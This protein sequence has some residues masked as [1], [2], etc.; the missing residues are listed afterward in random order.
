MRET[1]GRTRPTT[2]RLKPLFQS[3][4]RQCGDCGRHFATLAEF[5]D[6]TTPCP[7]APSPTESTD[8]DGAHFVDV[9]RR[10]TCGA[11]LLERC[12]DRR[13]ASDGGRATRRRFGRAVDEMASAG[14]VKR[15]TLQFLRDMIRMS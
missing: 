10:C 11:R 14:P 13:D 6:E 9:K 12:A 1:T 8:D 2:P 15:S 7:D 3:F 5:L 4:P